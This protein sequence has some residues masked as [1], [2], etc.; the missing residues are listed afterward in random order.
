MATNELAHWGHAVLFKDDWERN[1]GSLGTYIQ[2]VRVTIGT[3]AGYLYQANWDAGNKTY[4]QILSE[5]EGTSSSGCCRSPPNGGRSE[6]AP[7]VVGA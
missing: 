4:A 1:L 3:E 7:R 5:Y 6:V 2:E